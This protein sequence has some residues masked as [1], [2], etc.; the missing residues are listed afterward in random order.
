ML[1]RNWFFHSVNLDNKHSAH[2]SCRKLIVYKFPLGTLKFQYRGL[3]IQL[4]ESQNEK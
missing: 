4:L 1:E 2:I 3:G